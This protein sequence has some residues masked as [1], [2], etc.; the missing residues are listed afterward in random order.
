MVFNFKNNFNIILS[1][2]EFQFLWK[3]SNTAM[4]QK[5]ARGEL[6]PVAHS[7]R[8]IRHR[9]RDI[10]RLESG[11]NQESRPDLNRVENRDTSGGGG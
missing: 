8:L 1:G 10:E 7:P 11:A 6:D 3:C 5:Q 4:K 9:L 2:V